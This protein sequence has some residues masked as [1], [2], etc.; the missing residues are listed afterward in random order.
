MKLAFKLSLL[1]VMTALA[2]FFAAAAWGT[3]RQTADLIPA[4]VYAQ[5]RAKN[6]R[7]QYFLREKDGR[8]AVFK[9]GKSEPE[10]YTGIETATLRRADSAM[11]EKGIPA[12]DL[13]E[14]LELLEDLG[15]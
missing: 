11:L 3:L 14:L 8:V 7:A 2:A 1:T 4:E 10:R 5:Y 9:S 15:S 12:E 13:S 6:G